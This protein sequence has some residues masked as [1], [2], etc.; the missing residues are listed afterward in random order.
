MVVAIV[1]VVMGCDGD[2]DGGSEV[3]DNDRLMMIVAMMT[4]ISEGTDGDG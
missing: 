3:C 4:K 1:V 2:G